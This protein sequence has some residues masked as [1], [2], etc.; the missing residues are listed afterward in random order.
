[1]GNSVH[2]GARD[3][4]LRREI[5]GKQCL[6][7]VVSHPSILRFLFLKNCRDIEVKIECSN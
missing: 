6:L 3:A 7:M 4:T 2:V 1:M 5:K